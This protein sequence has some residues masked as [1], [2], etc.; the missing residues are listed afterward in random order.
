MQERGAY[1]LRR[2]L[3]YGCL[4]PR[5]RFLSDGRLALGFVLFPLLGAAPAC[6]QAP[7]DPIRVVVQAGPV[8]PRRLSFAPGRA[9]RLLVVEASGLIGLWDIAEPKEPVLLLSLPAGALEARFSSDGR[10]IFSIGLDGK[11]SAWDLNG[12]LQWRAAV[13]HEGRARAL[14]VGPDRLVTGGGDGTVRVWQLDGKP[15]GR[16]L[17]GHEGI[18]VSIDVAPDGRILS[19]ATDGNVLLWRPQPARPRTYAEPLALYEP[20]EKHK[21]WWTTLI[22]RDSQW[23]WDRAVAFS[24]KDRI[25]AAGYDGALRFFAGDG[26]PQ[27]TPRQGHGGHHVR[28]VAFA[29]EGELLASA[30][31]DGTVRLWSADGTVRGAPIPAHKGPALCVAIAP[32]ASALAT[33]GSDD[34]VRLWTMDGAPIGELPVGRRGH[35]LAVA[36][37]PAARLLAAGSAAGTIHLWNLD[38]TPHGG[39]IQGHRGSVNDVRFS[40]EGNLLATAGQDSTVRLWNLDGTPRAAPI[41]GHSSEVMSVAIS[42]D[43]KTIATGSRMDPVQLWNGDATPQPVKLVGLRDAVLGLAFS[44]RGDLLAGADLD[45]HFWIWRL[46]G[47]HHTAELVGHRGSIH[48]IAFSPDGTLLASA[49]HDG[50]VRLWQIDGKPLGELLRVAATPMR[51]VAFSPRGDLLAAG[52][53]DGVLRLWALPSRRLEERPL[54][55]RINQIGF[56]GDGL[57]VRSNGD[58]IRFFARGREPVVTMLLDG[59]GALAFTADGWISG[60]GRPGRG[61]RLFRGPD[62]RLSE[63]EVTKR[64]SPERVVEAILGG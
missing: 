55:L 53:D 7:A 64:I 42:P 32:D 47:T 1:S 58:Q 44:P 52:G 23:G 9:S 6:R 48:D 26:S 59:F 5:A 28:A 41:A 12:R 27:G 38:G 33:A 8:E 34:R 29:P 43:G 40:S 2:T 60:M 62:I 20:G 22:E 31:F 10:S 39:P 35:I 36:I 17:K 14:A 4:D 16:A 63:A 18:V 3:A 57:W 24:T 45:G 51:S 37:A 46:D 21:P 49:G 19:A 54:G 56:A 25:V 13:G 50:T 61:V 30:G 11:L 15:A